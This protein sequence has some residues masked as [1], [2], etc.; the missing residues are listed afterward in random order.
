M[1]PIVAALERYAINGGA[2]LALAADL[3]VVGEDAFLQVGEVRLGM[4]APYNLGWLSLRHG[5]ALMARVALLGERLAGTQ[6][7]RLGI[8]QRVV[9]GDDVLDAA[10]DWCD[11]LAGFPAGSLERIKAGLRARLGD[12]A[13]DWFDRFTGVGSAARRPQPQR[14]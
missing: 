6:L 3:L 9:P 7:E 14:V 1:E 12:T 8:A 2:A 5:E 13:D 4:A 10:R 11:Q